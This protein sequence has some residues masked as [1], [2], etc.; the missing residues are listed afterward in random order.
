MHLRLDRR[1]KDDDIALGIQMGLT[2][3]FLRRRAFDMLEVLRNR[4]LDAAAIRIQAGSRMSIARTNLQ[5]SILAALILQK[6]ARRIGAIRYYNKLRR[7]R[8][9]TKIQSAWR[10]FFAERHYMA[11]IWIVRWCQRLYRGAKARDLCAFMLLEHVVTLIQNHWR[12]YS[13]ICRYHDILWAVVHLQSLYRA[14]KAREVFRQLKID[15][16]DLDAVA[17]ERDRFRAEALRLRQE[18]ESK[19]AQ[20]RETPVKA[21]GHAEKTEAS[22]EVD[23]LKQEIDMLQLQLRK[24]QLTKHQEEVHAL[25]AQSAEKDAELALLRKE[26]AALRSPDNPKRLPF[27][28]PARSQG[29]PGKTA[30]AVNRGQS[31]LRKN[32]SSIFSNTHLSPARSEQ[33]SR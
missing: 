25:A 21:N 32:R 4:R 9:A 30:T 6:F 16:H 8:A 26:V 24:T 17:A 19:E 12:R 33:V 22:P 2:K 23:R 15:A 18:L 7:R 5:I 11:A 28:S 27:A 14:R 13:A 31:P 1:N 3:V 20:Q 29:S 10:G